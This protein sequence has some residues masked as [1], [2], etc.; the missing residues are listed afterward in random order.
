MELLQTI[1]LYSLN[2]NLPH[3]SPHIGAALASRHVRTQLVLRAFEAA[4]D[5]KNPEHVKLQSMLLRQ[6][7]LTYGFFQH[8]QKTYM[9]HHAVRAYQ[10]TVSTSKP[11]DI[12]QNLELAEMG[13]WFNDYYDVSSRLYKKLKLWFSPG[14]TIPSEDGFGWISDKG[15]CYHISLSVGGQQMT[16]IDPLKNQ[17]MMYRLPAHGLSC[18]IPEKLLHGPWT[19][20]KGHLLALL[21]ACGAKIGWIDST[22][23]EVATKGLEDAIREDNLSA[24]KTLVRSRSEYSSLSGQFE[25]YFGTN[26]SEYDDDK[27]KEIVAPQSKWVFHDIE[28]SRYGAGVIPSTEHLKIAVFEKGARPDIVQALTKGP[29]ET[30]IACDDPEILQWAA[31]TADDTGEDKSDRRSISRRELFAILGEERLKQAHLRDAREAWSS[32]CH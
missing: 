3:A 20:E 31:S 7:W 13:M 19:H 14:K 12:N 30:T 26:A 11:P 23:G 24:V 2:L 5:P 25:R 22:R 1:F 21:L 16:I 9:F 8:C 18:E 10:S 17:P 27:L 29:I 6:K 15:E 32:L 28:V 4:N